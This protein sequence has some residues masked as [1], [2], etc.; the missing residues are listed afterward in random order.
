MMVWILMMVLGGGYNS[1]TPATLNVPNF[2]NEAACSTA[3]TKMAEKWINN[4][5]ST[6]SAVWVC[7]RSKLA[8][9]D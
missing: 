4:Y 9:A 3:G 7:V 5:P 8:D 6:R 2:F 1:S